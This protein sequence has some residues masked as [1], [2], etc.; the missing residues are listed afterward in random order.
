MGT[1][2]KTLG[3]I[4][5]MHLAWLPVNACWALLWGNDDPRKCQVL[6]LFQSYELGKREFERCT[7]GHV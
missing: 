5:T 6:N 4:G 2:E 3:P 1:K 7:E